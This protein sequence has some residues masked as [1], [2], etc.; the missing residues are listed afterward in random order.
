MSQLR[1][2]YVSCNSHFTLLE[3]QKCIND[4]DIKRAMGQNSFLYHLPKELYFALLEAINKSWDV[5]I[6]L[7]SFKISSLIPILKPNRDP[8][9]TSSYKPIV[10][11]SYLGK[12]IGRLI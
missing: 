6:F 10:L 12:F 3:L 9:M 7:G 4:L 5:G 11:L 2:I 1:G 8:H